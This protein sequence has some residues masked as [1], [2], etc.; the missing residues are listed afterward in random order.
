MDIQEGRSLAR[1][2]VDEALSLVDAKRVAL[3]DST[4][5]PCDDANQLKEGEGV[6]KLFVGGELTKLDG[7][8][9]V[10]ALEERLPKEGWR[11]AISADDSANPKMVTLRKDGF[12]LLASGDQAHSQIAI[13]VTSPCLSRPASGA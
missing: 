10:L 1:S 5:L 2:Y 8:A 12:T 7:R 9:A 13:T 11:V 6:A 3:D 4:P